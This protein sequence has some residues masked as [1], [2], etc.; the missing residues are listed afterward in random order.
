MSDPAPEHLSPTDAHRFDRLGSEAEGDDWRSGDR[1]PSDAEAPD[2][3]T[4]FDGDL[5]EL[6][7]AERVEAL[8]IAERAYRRSRA[9]RLEAD[10]SDAVDGASR[11]Q[12]RSARDL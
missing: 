12:T 11:G 5:A 2:L 8:E 6:G 3:A 4:H 9:A 10:A 1:T 7:D